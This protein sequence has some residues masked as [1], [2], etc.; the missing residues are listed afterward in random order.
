M[1]D[2]CVKEKDL[3]N[4]P[5]NYDIPRKYISKRPFYNLSK[6]KK[7]SILSH[8]K[9]AFSEFN[10]A[11][12][13]LYQDFNYE[14]FKAK[15]IFSKLHKKP[16]FREKLATDFINTIYQKLNIKKPVDKLY[17]LIDLILD[18]KIEKK[19]SET[20]SSIINKFIF[21]HKNK[22][23]MD[24]SINLDDFMKF[25]L[26]NLDIKIEDEFKTI[27]EPENFFI[28]SSLEDNSFIISKE[29]I[30]N[31]S[32]DLKYSQTSKKIKDYD[33][34]LNYKIIDKTKD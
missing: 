5:Y 16:K 34:I 31:I 33:I 19:I 9:T 11:V 15:R 3:I 24:L 30:E 22:I 10:I 25:S 23:I 4:K 29:N 2:Y 32:K 14:Y 28:Y 18:S 17:F 20:F 21:L 7:E 26:M 13:E 6:Y 8:K 27:E 12:S 1:S